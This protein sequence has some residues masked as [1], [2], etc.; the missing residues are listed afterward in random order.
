VRR[1]CKRKHLRQD[2]ESANLPF[3][4]DNLKLAVMQFQIII[5]CCGREKHAD[6]GNFSAI[7]LPII[8]YYENKS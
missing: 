7:E 8:F 3:D 5:I 4:A 2:R 6:G 1:K